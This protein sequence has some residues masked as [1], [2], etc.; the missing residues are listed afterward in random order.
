MKYSNSSFIDKVL[1]RVEFKEA[2]TEIAQELKSHI[3]ELEET[4]SKVVTDK[5]SLEGEILKCMGSPIEVGAQLNSIHRPRTDWF[6]ILLVLSLLLSGYVS[7][8]R[9]GFLGAQLLWSFIGLA[10][11]TFVF[12]QNPKSLLRHSHL[13]YVALIIITGFSLLSATYADGQPYISVLGLNIKIIDVSSALFV[14]F[15]PALFRKVRTD[16]WGQAWTIVLAIPMLLLLKTGSIFPAVVFGV[17]ILGMALVSG[18]SFGS[19][20]A[21][22]LISSTGILLVPDSEHFISKSGFANW[23]NES[24]TDFILLAQNSISPFIT[25]FVCILSILAGVRL[26]SMAR[27]IKNID[28]RTSVMGISIFI[29]LSVLWCVVAN[30]GY[31][32]MPTTGINLP[33]V[34]YGGSMMIAQLAMIGIALSYYR[35]RSL[36]IMEN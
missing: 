30:F 11:A 26:F 31:A 2:H 14:V 34:S 10:I 6:L 18:I 13:G 3:A 21:F 22:I 35:R 32:P 33:F 28:G 36:T 16:R 7:M 4:L 17:S 8:A 25:A 1:E 20:A 9:L 24:H 5:S 29:S 19:V 12:F 15:A 27:E 23:A